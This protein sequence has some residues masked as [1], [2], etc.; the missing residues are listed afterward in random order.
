M[1]LGTLAS[2]HYSRRKTTGSCRRSSPRPSTSTQ[3]VVITTGGSTS[4]T[5]F[6]QP[7]T[8]SLVSPHCAELIAS[9]SVSLVSLQRTSPANG[10]SYSRIGSNRQTGKCKSSLAI[11]LRVWTGILEV[12]GFGET[13]ESSLGL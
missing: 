6:R 4:T 3:P 9:T 7:A 13:T 8:T 11:G 1:R 5:S 10:H 12:W 2:W